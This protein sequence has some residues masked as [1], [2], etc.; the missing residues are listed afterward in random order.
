VAIAET[1][2][3]LPTQAEAYA[4]LADALEAAGELTELLDATS[5]GLEVSA[6]AGDDAAIAQ[7]WLHRMQAH[8]RLARYDDALGDELAATTAIGRAG[9]DV[10]LRARLVELKGGVWMMRA[11]FDKATT[12]YRQALALSEQRTDPERELAIATVRESLATVLLMT[13]HEVEART[14]LERVVKQ[15]EAILGP[16]HPVVASAYFRLAQAESMIEGDE[17]APVHLR[18]A[19]AIQEAT[20]GDVQSTAKT[21]AT[22]AGQLRGRKQFDEAWAMFERARRIFETTGGNGS[23]L[24]GLLHNEAMLR[25]DQG[26]AAEEIELL[27]RALEL[28]EK[29]LGA[30]DPGVGDLTYELSEALFEVGG[31]DEEVEQLRARVLAM[32][33]AAYGEDH[34]YTAAARVVFGEI[35]V[36]RGQLAAA[37]E[38]CGRSLAFFEQHAPPAG[39][40]AG[41][42]H[43]LGEVELALGNVGRATE[44]AERAV[45]VADAVTT[46]FLLA[47]A[48][49]SGGRDPARAL[50]EARK[51]SVLADA[52]GP[53]APRERA[54]I[55]AWQAARARSSQIR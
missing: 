16:S 17:Q 36:A 50:D 43:C 19:L 33:R 35:A 7:H 8:L 28:G 24:S 11:D 44:L 27:R 12:L 10:R 32:R 41:A 31:A 42:L 40:L 9:G 47:R 4:R 29:T 3:H 54:A 25:R 38:A 39:N 22:L 48:L 2:G 55:A 13:Q 49:W 46:R 21:L 20:I 14:E 34:Q 30:Q 18:R 1:L 5:R 52:L 15:L 51:A 23:A 26:R 45:A 6:R 53:A 37:R